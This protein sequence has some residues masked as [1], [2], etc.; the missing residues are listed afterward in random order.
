MMHP[1][2]AP[3]AKPSRASCMG[4]GASLPPLKKAFPHSKCE[5]EDLQLP[6]FR[7][8]RRGC[9]SPRGTR[10]RSV[11]SRELT[12]APTASSPDPASTRRL[13]RPL[14]QHPDYTYP[15]H[16]T[17]PGSVLRNSVALVRAASPR[18]PQPPRRPCPACPRG[19]GRPSRYRATPCARGASTPGSPARPSSRRRTGTGNRPRSRRSPPCRRSCRCR[20]RTTRRRGRARRRRSSTPKTK[21]T[22]KPG[23]CQARRSL[24]TTQQPVV[25]VVGAPAENLRVCVELRWGLCAQVVLFY[26]EARRLTR[27][28][29]KFQLPSFLCFFLHIT[30]QTTALQQCSGQV[31]R[32]RR[33]AQ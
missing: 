6:V 5:C 22:A 25:V 16:S 27:V 28:F 33:I 31:T 18:S 24:D 30:P 12:W 13:R 15:P 29:G 20:R 7:R 8:A 21:S 2:T 23:V 14:S 19:T 17:S 4:D 3:H 26:N 1:E 9:L 10:G 32:S 11:R